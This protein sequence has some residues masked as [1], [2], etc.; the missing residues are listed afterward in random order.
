M[1]Q[2]PQYILTQLYYHVIIYYDYKILILF[3][4]T[5]SIDIV[6]TKL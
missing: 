6:R 1:D 2:L 5:D 4:I 3:C